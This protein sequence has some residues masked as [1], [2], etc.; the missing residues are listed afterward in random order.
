MIHDNGVDY[1]TVKDAAK[2]I[3]CTPQ[4]VHYLIKVGKLSAFRK[5]RNVLVLNSEVLEYSQII[6]L[7]NKENAENK[8]LESV[9]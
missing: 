3:Q 1:L 7:K 9:A 2:K 6:P 4:N 8:E 5:A